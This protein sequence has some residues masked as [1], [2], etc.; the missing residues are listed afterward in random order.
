MTGP[1]FA[2]A[3]YAEQWRRG[4]SLRGEASGA[5][6]EMMLDLADIRTDSRVLDVAA[7]TR[8]QTLF[9]ARRVACPA[10]R[11]HTA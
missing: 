5:A 6:T 2:S 1:N 9:V 8:D 7:G 4:K 10:G 3:E 11:G